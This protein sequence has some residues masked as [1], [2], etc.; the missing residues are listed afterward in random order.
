MNKSGSDRK[1][2]FPKRDIFFSHCYPCTTKEMAS[3]HFPSGVEEF[4]CGKSETIFLA[5]QAT[6]TKSIKWDFFHVKCIKFSCLS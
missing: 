6:K 2:E 5:Y 3:S 1:L 4:I